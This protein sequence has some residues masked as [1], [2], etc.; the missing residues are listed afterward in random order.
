MVEGVNGASYIED[1]ISKEEA[2]MLYERVSALEWDE[3]M[4]RRK[5]ASFG[6][7]YNYVQMTYDEQPIPNWLLQYVN[8]VE[9][10]FGFVFNNVLLNL[11]DHGQQVIGWHGD[12]T[13][14]LEP[15]TGI[16]ILSLGCARPFSFRKYRDKKQMVTITVQPGS[17][18]A[19]TTT[20]QAEWQH[21]LLKCDECT[22]RR[23]SVTFRRVADTPRSLSSQWGDPPKVEVDG[24]P[25][26]ESC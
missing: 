18:L 6:K 20:M 11:Y 19:M 21:A 7:P 9:R 3:S 12:H 24:T 5:T 4:Q 22:S 10:R 16:V 23:V 8:L 15:G 1:A 26:N 14:A 13:E 2:D 17:F 25:L